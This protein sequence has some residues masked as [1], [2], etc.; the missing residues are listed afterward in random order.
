[1][2]KEIEREVPEATKINNSIIPNFIKEPIIVKTKINADLITI[3]SLEKRKNQKYA[4]EIIHAMKELGHTVSLTI[5]G[6]GPDMNILKAYA[7]QL[8]VIHL[9]NFIG[10]K[11]NADQYLSNHKAYL[12]TAN[13]ENLPISIIEALSRA[14]PIFAT[15]VGGIPEMINDNKE[16]LLLTLGE[17]V[18]SAEK[19][20]MVLNDQLKLNDM[21][22]LARLKFEKNYENNSVSRKLVKFIQG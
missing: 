18:K 22:K 16:G 10:F 1:M 21:S 15:N 7:E 13:I 19:I 6:D 3:G 8:N 4:I 2:K 20:L 14:L 5:V 12:H 9:I 17:P 11:K